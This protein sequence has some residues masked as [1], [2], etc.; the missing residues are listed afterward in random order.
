MKKGLM[1]RLVALLCVTVL[2]FCDAGSVLAQTGSNVSALDTEQDEVGTPEM[3]E[4]DGT[5]DE[6]EVPD[7]PEAPKE[8]VAPDTP[9]A[10]DEPDEPEVPD[11]PDEPEIPDTPEHIHAYVEVITKE[12]ST[13]EKGEKTYTCECGDSYI[14]EIAALPLGNVE[15]TNVKNEVD[16]IVL[17]W[18][19]VN[20]ADTYTIYRDDKS[21]ELEE[22]VELAV[23][24]GTE[25]SFT[26]AD[27]VSGVFYSYM[28][29][30][31]N[32]VS[33]SAMSVAKD[34][35][36]LEAPE[37]EVE[38]SEEGIYLSWDEIDGAVEY[39]IQKYLNG[40]FL[41]D[42]SVGG[43]AWMDDEAKSGEVYLYKVFAVYD[44]EEGTLIRGAK[45]ELEASFTIPAAPGDFKVKNTGYKQLKLTWDAVDGAEG[46]HIYRSTSEDQ[47][48]V[49][50]TSTENLNYTDKG[51]TTN[52]KYYYKV[53]A[54]NGNVL[55]ELTE[56]KS[57][58]PKVLKPT[59][60]KTA[61]V[62][63]TSIKVSWI[64]PDGATG[65]Y[66]YRKKG[67]GSWTKIAT[68]TK[69]STTSY[70]DKKATGKYSY[71]VIAYKK[72][73]G[74]TFTSARSNVIQASVLKKAT[75]TVKQ[76]STKCA[77]T[78]KWEKVN[79]ATGYQVY[80]KNGKNG[81]WKLVKTTGSS[82]RSYSQNME[83]GK[84]VYFKVRAIRKIDGTTTYA[85]YS[86]SKSF[87]FSVPEF[88][89]EFS[90]GYGSSVKTFKL[91]LKNTGDY[92]VRVYSKNALL[93]DEYNDAY[94][95]ELYLVNSSGKKLNY[96]DVGAGKTKTMTFKIDGNSTR[97]REDSII[98]FVFKY[99]GL[100]YALLAYAD[101]YD[102][103]LYLADELFE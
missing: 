51:L 38:L 80:R 34:F 4:E 30:A 37:V 24:E 60:N 95:R 85:P 103:A 13:T 50:V 40:E 73:D 102:Q 6:P 53:R 96:T 47:G 22:Y 92:S 46:Y 87:C 58:T 57:G 9:E 21:D 89:Y 23:V 59:M 64:K 28:I 101:G 93:L 100:E 79:N 97:Y 5:M 31:G 41:D 1:K 12:P 81:T 25:N 86:S 7:T 63:G 15:F 54:Y 82:A 98:C 26:D 27:V 35:I 67:S 52:Q 69:A 56:A 36:Y 99:D 72:A 77:V 18:E 90:S 42:A 39:Y 49:W 70:T 3:P 32:A 19:F 43:T 78:V 75:I 44:D 48:Y 66:V 61:N 62:T 91:T 45:T 55:G 94:S 68:I 11:T 2:A 84:T 20:D 71:S 76:K 14:E 74:Q 29:K 16:G 88:I 17:T 65:Y 83:L 10:P 8:D 33:E